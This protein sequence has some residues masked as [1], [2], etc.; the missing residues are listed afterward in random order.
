MKKK[1]LMLLAT[2][3]LAIGIIA[4]APKE[5]VHADAFT[6]MNYEQVVSYWSAQPAF[7]QVYAQEAAGSIYD[8]GVKNDCTSYFVAG[9]RDYC[10]NPE[11]L[12]IYCPLTYGYMAGVLS[13]SNPWIYQ[14]IVYGTYQM[15]SL[16][17]VLLSE[18]SGFTMHKVDYYYR[19]EI[20]N[21]LIAYLHAE[22]VYT[23]DQ[24]N[25]WKEKKGMTA[26]EYYLGKIH[27]FEAAKITSI[28]DATAQ[29]EAQKAA[30][31]ANAQAQ[32]QQMA[33]QMSAVAQSTQEQMNAYY[34]QQVEQM[35][36]MFN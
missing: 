28:Q 24:Y 6:D 2:A 27:E 16:Y 9:L 31:I 8:A 7:A 10:F 20:V 22:G 29:A 35:A 32:Q 4:V 14:Y 13:Y 21:V 34:N 19:N 12:R 23:V 11:Y 36:N 25:G 33:E 26:Y 5:T 17:D 18:V 15:Y 1:L 30:A 3:F